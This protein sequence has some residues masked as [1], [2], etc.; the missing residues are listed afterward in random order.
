MARERS[1]PVTGGCNEHRGVRRLLGALLR[2]CHYLR[3]QLIRKYPAWRDEGEQ[4]CTESRLVKGE[5]KAAL[6]VR[7][8]SGHGEYNR[9]ARRGAAGA[10]PNPIRW[11]LLLPRLA[12]PLQVWFHRVGD[13]ELLA[14]PHLPLGK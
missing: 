7:V 4:R 6:K 10:S 3:A 5:G 8:Y 11:K 14:V 9:R 13:P 2:V 12:S 1:V